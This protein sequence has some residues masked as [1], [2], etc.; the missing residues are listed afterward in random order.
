MIN[1][2]NNYVGV[3]M[4]VKLTLQ[5]IIDKAIKIHDK[6]FDYSYIKEYKN[7]KTYVNILC[8]QCQRV[9]SQTIN[10]H[11]S[12]NGCPFCYGRVKLTLQQFID[13]AIKIHDKKFDYSYIKE[14]KNNHCKVP[15]MC[16]QCNNIFH[17]IPNSHLLGIGCPKCRISK[18]ELAIEQFL[19][20][21]NIQY[22]IQKT[23]NDCRG[24]KRPLPFDFYLP[25]HNICIE[26][27]GRQHF[28]YVKRFGSIDNFNI[29]KLHDSIKNQYCIDKKIKLIRIP[30]KKLKNV[31]LILTEMIIK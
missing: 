5:Q 20:E 18:G 23:F 7:N 8:N 22:E 12:G 3:F 14:Y 24:K 27:D 10:A 15:I 31:K 19:K 26:F 16:L 11:L 4:P 29:I 25:D 6:K 17:Q 2:I 30:Y 13:K 28:E 1:K 21:H 9:F